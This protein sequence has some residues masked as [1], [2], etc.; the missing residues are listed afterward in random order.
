[1]KLLKWFSIGAFLLL[2]LIGL[3]SAVTSAPPALEKKAPTAAVAAPTPT[4]T[5][6]EVSADALV[7]IA[8]ATIRDQ[9]KSPSLANFSQVKIVPYGYRQ[10]LCAGRVES[11]NSFG[12]MIQE[13]WVAY[14]FASPTHDRVDYMVI[15]DTEYGSLPTAIP[16]PKTPAEL[17]A[18]EQ[19]AKIAQAKFEANK[20]SGAEKALAANQAA[21][22]KGDAYGLLRMGERYRDGEGVGKDLAKAKDYLQRA[23][24]AGSPTAAEEL[25]R[26]H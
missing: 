7:A 10:W 25:A 4:S 8:Q 18:A 12:A 20:K 2:L 11:Q 24:A 1:M 9:L 17:V 14:V 22:E 15:G 5:T 13:P 6:S 16:F 26:L 23:A 21:A 19:A 3:L